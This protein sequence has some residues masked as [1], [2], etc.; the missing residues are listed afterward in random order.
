MAAPSKK[1]GAVELAGRA[2][3]SLERWER[4]VTVSA[5][6]AALLALPLPPIAAGPEIAS[7]LAVGAVITLAGVRWGM[8]LLVATEVL[9]L[10]TFA[11]FVVDGEA[12]D[13][14][15]LVGAASCLATLP[16][17]WSIRRVTP[18]ALALLGMGAH[19]SAARAARRVLVA[20]ALVLVALPL[21]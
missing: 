2:G 3:V 11:P 12:G 8:A 7:T 18:H 5:L 6:I 21:F 16:G 1:L 17:L 20:G 19:P 13:G 15:R 14:L 9:L 10:L 4:T